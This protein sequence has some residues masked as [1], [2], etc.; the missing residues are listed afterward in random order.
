V[1]S[2]SKMLFTVADRLFYEPMDRYA[3]NANAFLEPVR[4]ML[5][6]GW[7]IHRKDLWF[8]A[9]PR[10]L[11][12]PVQGWKIHV[13]ATQANA[14]EL[15]QRIVPLLVRENISFKFALD[16]LVLSIITGKGWSISGV[17][18]FITIY[19]GD[20]TQFINTAEE[21]HRATI[22]I[23]GPYIV[24]DRR[25]AE[26]KV[27]YYRYGGISPIG[28]SNVKGEKTLV[29]S[30]PDGRLVPDERS[31]RFVLPQWINDPF[32]E[33]QASPGDPPTTLKMGRYT[34][35]S[36]LAL[37]S[38]GA[39]YLA[40]DTAT[41]AQVV[42]KQA[43]PL[44]NF[45]PGGDDS[46]RLLEREYRLLRKIEGTGIA[47]RPQDFFAEGEQSYLVEE[48]LTN[49]TPLRFYS[50]SRTVVLYTKPT[51]EQLEAFWSEYKRI[52]LRIAQLLDVLHK[53]GIVFMDFSH[54]N[55]LVSQDG[56]DLRLID[57][58]G[59]F[60]IGRDGPSHLSTPGFVSVSD[61]EADSPGFANDYF[62]FGATMLSFLLPMNTLM[63]LDPV[64]HIRFLQAITADFGLPAVLEELIVRLM[65]RDAAARPS[66]A[67]VRAALE[68]AEVRSAPKLQVRDDLDLACEET[69]EG[70][71]RHILDVAGY[72]RADRL[73]PSDPKVFITNPLS[74]A[75][76]AC[77]VAWSLKAITG[78][79]SSRITDWILQQRIDADSY[80]PGL[81]LGMAG[82]AWVFKH[83]GLEEKAEELMRLSWEHPLLAES[84]DM[85]YGLAGWGM[86]QLRFFV[87]TGKE[88]Y[89]RQAIKAGDILASTAR[90]E[91]GACY[92]PQSTGAVTLGFAH[93][94]S[95]ISIFLLHL[96]LLAD[97][98]KFLH[99]G[100]R[101]LDFDIAAAVPNIE[102]ALS[103]QVRRVPGAPGM[104]YLRYGSAGVGLALI[105][106]YRAL[107]DE[108]YKRVLD[109]L[110]PDTIRKY[111]IYPGRFVGLTGIGEF[112]LALREI[113]SY[114]AISTAALQRVITGILLFRVNTEKGVAFPGYELYR[115][116][117]DYATGSAGIA[118]FLHQY[119][120]RQNGSFLLDDVLSKT[121]RPR[122]SVPAVHEKGLIPAV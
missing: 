15:L 108:Y 52:F 47:P 24:S 116:S 122:A 55:V 54:N 121:K 113:E 88:E 35:R 43:R 22:G 29:L 87:D 10:G 40:D 20:E 115:F 99:L 64:A 114:D 8:N 84:P 1:S 63:L 13:S 100:K 49:S 110:L 86:A 90:D 11:T 120:T 6:P 106:Y 83:I 82:I 95:G 5:P 46:I 104:P 62:A 36:L 23:E 102:G 72:D 21:L 103:W 60:E 78:D 65:S 37:S 75:Y 69:I 76:G 48:Y 70:V 68:N 101:A 118:L 117:C 79:L 39:V 93:G 44:L 59:A 12:L 98:E 74:I 14:R 66:F 80:P 92:W 28:V 81:Y 61:L 109:Q 19:F 27:I 31:S 38:C 57:L 25:Y 30:T 56:Q 16:P 89:L 34:V 32:P 107:G 2:I 9:S 41:G 112:L 4:L 42:I 7:Q 119:R 45:T 3:V 85:V 97:D 58:E 50:G 51:R 94:S 26:S 77:G 71:V 18:K 17:G 96:Y 91:N 33:A 73:F 111:G 53:H 67:E 105:H